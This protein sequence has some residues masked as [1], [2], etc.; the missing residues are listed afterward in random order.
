MLT[1]FFMDRL[2]QLYFV[3][4]ALKKHFSS[5]AVSLFFSS[6]MLVENGISPAECY[7]LLHYLETEEQVIQIV[8]D[9]DLLASPPFL[10]QIRLTP[11]FH[12]FFRTI[13]EEALV[14]L[15]EQGVL[16]LLKR[17]VDRLSCSR[18]SVRLIALFLRPDKDQVLLLPSFD[19]PSTA[20]LKNFSVEESLSRGLHDKYRLHASVIRL[21]HV[22]RDSLNVLTIVYLCDLL[23]ESDLL[24]SVNSVEFF[25]KVPHLGLKKAYL[26]GLKG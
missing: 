24:V 11:A 16:S 10:F 2:L 4:L 7:R 8:T 26:L 25:S 15:E 13:E 17:K 9:A 23:Q 6:D 21:L 18:E 3:L 20:L 1:F 5:S 14:A 12:P 22:F 19:L